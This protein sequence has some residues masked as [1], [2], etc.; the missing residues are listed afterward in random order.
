LTSSGA[1]STK[2]LLSADN[3]AAAENVFESLHQDHLVI[4]SPDDK[5]TREIADLLTRIRLATSP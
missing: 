3:K 2:F 1:S 4:N 5:R